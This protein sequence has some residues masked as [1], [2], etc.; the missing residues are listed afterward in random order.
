MAA[1]HAC[2]RHGNQDFGKVVAAAVMR[3]LAQGGAGRHAIAAAASALLRTAPSASGSGEDLGG[4]EGEEEEE[5]ASRLA[6]IR[7]AILQ[8]VRVAATTGLNHHAAGGLVPPDIQVRSNVAKHEFVL[9]R[10]FGELSVAELKKKQRG[11]RKRVGLGGAGLR[12]WPGQGEA[13]EEGRRRRSCRRR[14]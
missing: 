6:A 3:G 7:P 11:G 8:Q 2:G 5:V 4:A 14:A 9:G 10:P 12:G 1:V 13:G